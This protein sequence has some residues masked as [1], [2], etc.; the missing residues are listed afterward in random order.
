MTT[1]REQI[2]DLIK[3]N[4]QFYLFSHMLPD[5]D[6]IGSLLAMGEALTLMGKEIGMFTPGHIPF[7]YSFLNGSELV[8][9]TAIEGKSDWVSIVLD[10]SDA[11]RLSIFKEAALISNVLV[12]IDHHVTNQYYGTLNLVDPEASA[13]GE[14]VYTLIRDLGLELT[15]TMAESLYV[16]ISTDTGSFKYDN[17]TPYTHE[18]VAD[19]LR[20]ELSPG[21]LSQR[22][23]D[24]RPRSFYILLKEALSSL[25]FYQGGDIAIMTLSRDLRERS[26]ATTDDLDGIV[27]Y[28]RNIEGVELG[29]LFY[30]DSAEEVKV[31]F[32]SKTLDVSELAGR[33]NGGGHVR[34]AGCRLQGG[35]EEVKAQVMREALVLYRE[36][37]A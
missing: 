5:G 8:G 14:I 26:G 12:N 10:S 21:T 34:A 36:L 23:F 37:P 28:T 33:L 24:E 9:H 30:V 16:A 19:L 17:T 4:K 6:S 18:V 22:I 13:T 1:D 31:G 15:K 2:I 27:N 7:K 35:Y 25:E 3:Q 29:I 32:R 20:H 11:D